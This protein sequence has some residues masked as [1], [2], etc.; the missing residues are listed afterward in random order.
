MYTI[1]LFASIH[2]EFLLLVR[3]R[4]GLALMFLMPLAL[5]IVITIIQDN[6][7]KIVSNSKISLILVNNDQGDIG[8]TI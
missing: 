5:V 7:F 4:A 6:T 8:K 2:K 1:R 3:D